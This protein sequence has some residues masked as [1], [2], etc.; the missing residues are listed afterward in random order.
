MQRNYVCAIL[1]AS[2]LSQCWCLY[3]PT[4]APLVRRRATCL[5]ATTERFLEEQVEGTEGGGQAKGQEWSLSDNRTLRNQIVAVAVPALAA[6][7]VE[8]ALTMI[9]MY[10]VGTQ[11]SV[12]RATAGLAGLSVTGAIFNIVAAC[13]YS[14]CSGTTAVIARSCSQ[15]GSAVESEGANQLDTKK[16]GSVL[17]NGVV[18]ALALG[19]AFSLLLHR[20]SVAILQTFF[21]MDASVM[22][23]TADYLKVR[24]Y[25]LPFTLISYVV[26]GTCLAVQDVTTPMLSIL[27][28]SA[29]NIFLDYVMVF[30]QGGGLVGAA[31]ATSVATVL[32]AVV[33]LRRLA[34]RYLPWDRNMSPQA[35]L[36]T[37]ASYVDVRLA[38]FFFSTSVALLVGMLANTLTYSAGARISAS[39][40]EVALVQTAGI[41]AAQGAAVSASATA[42]LVLQQKTIHTAAHQIAMQVW[43]FTSYFATPLA[44]A[45]QAILPKDMTSGNFDRVD[46][47]IRSILMIGLGQALSSTFLVLLCLRG[48]PNLFTGDAAVQAAFQSVLPQCVLSQLLICLTTVVDGVYLGTNRTSDYIKVSL[49]STSL[50]WLYFTQ[51]MQRGMGIVGTWNGMMIFCLARAAYYACKVCRGGLFAYDRAATSSVTAAQTSVIAV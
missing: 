13:T 23:M 15:S 45:A 46:R 8:P 32:A 28:S 50:A 6:C 19:G 49:A 36:R 7:V 12:V 1:L 4:R 33:S 9:D 11:R 38:K 40:A 51:A 17:V 16:L 41:A 10:F 30:R 42:A 29:A 21:P 39:V 43:W 47:G 20:S 44:L 37:Y 3:L 31:Q 35:N 5:T 18:L 24:G 25:S 27:V 2:Y 22:G 34:K 26:I 48:L 14:L